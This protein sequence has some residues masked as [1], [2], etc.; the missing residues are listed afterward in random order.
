MTRLANIFLFLYGWA[1]N[2]NCQQSYSTSITEHITIQM[3]LILYINILH[4]TVAKQM[5]EDG[6]SSSSEQ[7]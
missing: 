1:R 7:F 3:L 6:N 5:E 4:Y 2:M